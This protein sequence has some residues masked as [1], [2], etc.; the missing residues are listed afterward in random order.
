[1]I[2]TR[3]PVT[4]LTVETT[5][6]DETT[7][8]LPLADPRQPLVWARGDDAFVGVGCALRLEFT[9]PDRM[10]DAGRAWAEVAHAATVNDE[11]GLPGSGLIAFGSFTF[12][13]LSGAT[14]VL[15]VP[16]VVYARRGD[17]QWVT[18]IRAT[19]DESIEEATSD[20]APEPELQAAE[21]A[22]T[23]IRTASA[24][25][26][27]PSWAPVTFR[28]GVMTERMFSDTVR[29]ATRSIQRAAVEKVVIARDVV[30]ELSAAADLRHPLASLRSDYPDCW[31]FAVDGLMGASPETLVRVHRGAVDARVLAGTTARGADDTADEEQARALAASAKERDEHDFAVQSVLDALRPHCADVTASDTP[32]TLQ[33][34]NLWHLATDVQASLSDRSTSLDLIHALHP[35]A[36]VAGTPTPAAIQL[37]EELESFDRGRYAGPVGWVGADGDGEWAIALRCAQVDE[38]GQVRAYAGCGI[39]AGS[40][41]RRELAE[42]AMKLRPIVDAFG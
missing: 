39:V 31:T 14:S 2:A 40:N 34:P 7:R 1:M 21:G 22:E 8:L 36:A 28:S 3:T 37:I 42:T 18:R 41:D 32:F 20:S 6:T 19:G 16:H 10:L 5:F 27:D 9:G 15:I 29:A 17:R 38:A 13:A 30:G 23:A 35:T 12:S 25:I 33:L 4:T 24:G 11:V 26:P